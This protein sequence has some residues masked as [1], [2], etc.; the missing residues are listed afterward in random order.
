MR[1]GV[2]ASR[3]V[4]GAVERNRVK[5]ALREAFWGLSDRLPDGHDFVLV[6]RPEIGELIEREGSRGR[7]RRAS[8]RPSQARPG[9]AFHV[10]RLAAGPDRAPTSA[11]SRRP[12]RAAAATSRPARPTRPSRSSASAPSAGLLL[13]AWRL[14]RCNP[15]SH[16]GFDPV[17]ERFTLG[18]ARSIPPTTTVRRT[19]DPVAANI[20]QPL[21][22]VANASSSSSTTTPASAGGCRSSP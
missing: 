6:A 14:L 15:F 8:K 20:L 10:K 22:D 5:R 1:L 19:R 11:G 16:G 12:A 17:P 21:I 9:G 3:K 7:P 4:G 2:S 18:S 13:A